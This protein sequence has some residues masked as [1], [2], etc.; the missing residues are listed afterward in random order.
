MD[1]KKEIKLSD[2]FKRKAKPEPEIA[3]AAVEAPAAEKKSRLKRD[4]KL[5]FPK[6]GGEKAPKEPKASRSR[7]R[8]GKEAAPATL[9]VPLMRAFNLLPM[10]DL[11]QTSTVRRASPAQLGLA[12]AGLVLIAAIASIF[13]I[14][15]AQV[16]DKERRHN[17]LR[18]Q[19]AAKNVIAQA[20][21]PTAGGDATLIQERDA[22]RGALGTALGARIAWDRLLRDLSLVLP[23]DVWLKSLRGSSAVATV[24]PAA[25]PPTD[26]SSG[27][28]NSFDIVGYARRQ[29]DVALLLSRMEVMPEIATVGLL[30]AV[31]T[32]VGGEDLVEFSVTATVK[33]QGEG[34]TP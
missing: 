11:R 14:T 8:S 3:K 33:S 29:E 1:L 30:S 12:V 26:P 17:E 34:G 31:A 21:E 5:S 7:G 22:R 27:A 24:D 15:N 4:V 9:Q 25:P 6:R 10:D 32:E 28:K 16:A 18:S 19:L 20:P 23:E 2:L 13:L